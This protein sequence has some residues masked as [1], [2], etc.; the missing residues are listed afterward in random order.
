MVVKTSNRKKIISVANNINA[1]EVRSKM[2]NIRAQIDS[3]GIT[4]E[5]QVE[6]EVTKNKKAFKNTKEMFQNQ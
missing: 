5:N 3:F 2:I 1:N 4:W 6:R